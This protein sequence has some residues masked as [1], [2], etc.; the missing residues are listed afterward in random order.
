MC[1]H[2]GRDNGVFPTIFFELAGMMASVSINDKKSI[3]AF[4]TTF[5]I[6]L[7]VFYLFP[8]NLIICLIILAYSDSPI[9]RKRFVGILNGLVE[10]RGKDNKRGN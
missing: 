3:L 10:L 4:R 5:G 9:V 2:T 6:F 1:R 7:K 8:A